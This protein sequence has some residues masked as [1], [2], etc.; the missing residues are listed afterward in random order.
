MQEAHFAVFVHLKAEPAWLAL[1][2]DERR[3]I[4]SQE[5]QPIL[6][7]YKDVSHHHF[8][9]EAF[10]GR[11][12][13]IEMFVTP[14]LRRFYALFEEFRDSSLISKPYFTIVDIFP[15]LADGYKA[16]EANQDRTSKN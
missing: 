4:T 11:S 10:S 1:S 3:R 6:E 12:S 15:T 13:D 7:K 2:R 8:D 5:I 9:A 16:F 14:D